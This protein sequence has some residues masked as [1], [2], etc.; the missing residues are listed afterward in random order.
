I[1]QGPESF[2]LIGEQASLYLGT[3]HSYIRSEYGYGLKIG[4]YAASDAI[5]IKEMTAN[6]GIG[7]NVSDKSKMGLFTNNKD[8]SKTLP[9]TH[10][11]TIGHTLD[12]K[13]L[14]L[15]GPLGSFGHGARLNF[16]DGDY[17]Y[18][19]EDEDD[20]LNIYAAQRISLT[21][22]NVGI[23]TTTPGAKLDVTGR[24]S[25][26]NT[27]S[28]VFIGEGAGQNDDFSD[29]RNIAIGNW[30]LYSNTGT[31]VGGTD[32]IAIGNMALY[33][34]TG[35]QYWGGHNV[36]VGSE[37]ML[38]N[39]IGEYNVAI[40]DKAL[41]SNTA[42]DYNVAVGSYALTNN[43]DGQKNVAIGDSALFSNNN[44]WF[45]VAIGER[46]GYK[47][48]DGWGN[49][50]IGDRAGYYETGSSKLYIDNIHTTTPLIWGDFY[51]ERLVINGNEANNPN[52]RTLFVNGEAGGTTVWYNNSDKRLKKNITTISSSLEKVLQLRG[53]NFEWKNTERYSEGSQMGFIAQEVQEVIPEVVDE[54]DGHYTMQ[55]SPIT[56]LLVEAVKE[57]QEMIE[58]LRKEID[59]LKSSK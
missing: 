57:Q 16:G 48:E 45:N 11:L 58:E 52:D 1:V 18:I 34:Y 31:T 32:N 41:H 46:A 47:N 49:V 26:S 56:A 20:Y 23:G 8:G 13:L 44:G 50:F 35:A 43:A 51:Y 30:A 53:V 3:V 28:S 17:A 42:G 12:T 5:A 29:N 10:R 33:S 40:G 9:I 36:A 24:I 27:G 22:G 2:D 4:T 21:G 59:K 19:E 39:T 54:N 7:T 15:I 37:S 14:R 6:V 25:I 38:S 55:Y